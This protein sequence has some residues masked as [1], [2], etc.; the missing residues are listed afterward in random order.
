MC[1]SFGSDGGVGVVLDNTG[2][3]Y[4]ENTDPPTHE[5]KEEEVDGD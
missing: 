1:I 4:Y 2:N 3:N 5:D